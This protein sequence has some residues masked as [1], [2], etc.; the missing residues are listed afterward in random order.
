[1]LWLDIKIML[2]NVTG[3][4]RD[5]L[6]IYGALAIQFSLALFFR[7][8]LGSLWPWTVVLA[9]ALANEYLDYQ[10]LG[11][12]KAPEALLRQEAYHDLWNTMLIPTVL[13]LIA[14]FW[15]TWMIGKSTE[16]DGVHT[17]GLQSETAV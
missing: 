15:P 16:I 9:A 2:E 1:M 8:S 6:H 7:R 13:M 11:L 10:R 3:L 12:S 4:D 14:R 17:N 5:A